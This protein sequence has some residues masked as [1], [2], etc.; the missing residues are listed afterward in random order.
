MAS[1]L[2]ITIRYPAPKPDI[3][4]LFDALSI[5]PA[6]MDPNLT[7]PPA[8]AGPFFVADY[9]PG[10]Y[11]R[12]ARNPNYFMRPALDSIRIDIQPNPDIE[13]TRFLRGELDLI[14]KVEPANFDRIAKEQPAA[15]RNLG[16][17]LDSEFMWF[18]QAPSTTVPAWKRKWFTSMAFRQAIR[19]SIHRDDIAR[20]VFR[21]HAHPAAG[22]VS[23]ANKF[24]FNAALKPLPY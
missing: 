19:D 14:N 15:A 11:V 13:L 21:G 20:I 16:P 1:P 12:L 8:S 10:E 17:S 9:K 24:W 18:N 4:R 3:E 2:E 22:P 5:I 7:K 6:K 23:P